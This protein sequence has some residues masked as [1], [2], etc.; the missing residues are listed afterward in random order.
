MAPAA[1]RQ[2]QTTTA[3][4]DDGVHDEVANLRAAVL[5]L[6]RRLRREV[7]TDGLSSTETAVLGHLQR[8]GPMTPGQLAKAEYV[9]PPSMT[10]VIEILE[11]RDLV[12]RDPHPTDGRQL[13]VSLTGNARDYIEASR[14]L[15][16]QWLLERLDQLD[17]ADRAAIAQATEALRRL[18]A[19][20]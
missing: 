12:R 14:E 11:Q 20:P 19:V 2:Q 15:R 4:V 3:T 18:A 7:A 1:L 5:V 13:L 17:D 16:T 6:A 9:R 8:C 10:R